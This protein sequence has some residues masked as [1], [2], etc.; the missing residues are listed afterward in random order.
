MG[1]RISMLW[2]FCV[3]AGRYCQWIICRET[4]GL[5]SPLLAWHIKQITKHLVFHFQF[6]AFKHF[7]MPKKSS[8]SAIQRRDSFLACSLDPCSNVATCYE[9]VGA[10]MYKEGGWVWGLVYT[11]SP[12]GDTRQ[13]DLRKQDGTTVWCTGR[14]P[15]ERFWLQKLRDDLKKKSVGLILF[16]EHSNRNIKYGV[17][18]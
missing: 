6:Y 9:G 13:C 17:L 4:L 14:P 15:L 11:I 18:C 7:L 1:L 16:K 3:C 10:C 8:E 5:D 12:P 2:F